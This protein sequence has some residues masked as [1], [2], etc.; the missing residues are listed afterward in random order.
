MTALLDVNC[1]VALLDPAHVCHEAAHAWFS[2]NR[3]LGWATCPLTE[4]GILRVISSPAYPG[5]RT[6]LRKA[7]DLVAT[8]VKADAHV[9]WPDAISILE[10]VKKKHLL[11]HRQITDLYLLA[12]AVAR[13][14]RLVTFDQG[15]Q[16]HAVSDARP[17]HMVVLRA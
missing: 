3:Q 2:E 16:L 5:R 4:N 15:I 9:F 17:N 10:T 11:G 12:L 8:F 6:T 7:F 1:L 13:D 14:G